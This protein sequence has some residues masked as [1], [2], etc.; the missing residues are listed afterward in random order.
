MNMNI[1]EK[2][3]QEHSL[4]TEQSILMGQWEFD[5]K[6]I[7][8]ALKAIAIVFPHFSLHDESH[9]VSILNN[10]VKMLGVDNIKKLSCTD[11]WLLLESAYSHDLGMVVTAERLDETL[12]GEDILK[13][14]MKI[15]AD[16][17]HPCYEYSKCFVI[18]DGKLY[19]KEQ[20]LK[21]DK[22]DAVRFLLADYFR[23]KHAEN[24]KK[25]LSSPMVEA[26]ISS[27]RT[28]IP[29]RLFGMLSDIC[30]A[31][32]QNFEAVM[33]LPQNEDGIGLDE[34]HPRF[35]ACML[36][37][38][39]LRDI[40]NNRFSESLMKTIK[41]MPADSL[42]H[43]EK[44][45]SISH[46]S[47][48]TKC[49]EIEAVCHSPKVAQVTQE[50]FD[51]ISDEF[52]TQTLK[53]NCIVPDGIA[54]YL[55]TLNYLR[56]KI[57]G[58]E[59]VNDNK[60]PKF[61]IDTAKAL[62]L[63]QG[64]N[65]YKDVFDALREIIQNAVDSTLIRI[66]LDSK[67]DGEVFDGINEDFLKYAKQYEIKV[68]LRTTEDGNFEVTIS[69]KGM[70]LKPEHLPF[71]INTGSSSKNIE[72][73]LII[74]EMPE[75]MRPSGVFG[76][77]F[78]SIFLLTDKVEITTK[79]YFEDKKMNIEMYSPNSPM[80]GDVYL[81][82]VDGTYDKGFTI[83]F[84][85]KKDVKL[86]HE[87][88]YFDSVPSEIERTFV[89]DRIRKDAIT[90][91]VPIW[92]YVDDMPVDKIERREFCYFDK[93]T[94][95]E[96]GF[97]ESITELS[98]PSSPSFYYRNAP[99]SGNG[100]ETRFISPYVNVHFGSAMDALTLDRSSF[101]LIGL[102]DIVD[103]TIVNFI[104]SDKFE[105]YIE[106]LGKE[107]QYVIIKLDGFLEYYNLKSKIASGKISS[108]IK[109]FTFN[110]V[111]GIDNKSIQKISSYKKIRIQTV[112]NQIISFI[113]NNPDEITI[114]ISSMHLALSNFIND[115]V[116]LIVKMAND[117]HNCCY[118][119]KAMTLQFFAGSEYVMSDR[120][121]ESDISLTMGDIKNHLM[122]T[123]GRFYV[124][125]IPGYNDIRIPSSH[126]D[127]FQTVS[128]SNPPYSGIS[129]ERI[130]SPFVTINNATYDCRNDNFYRYVHSVNGVDVDK[131]RESYDRFVAEAQ[132]F[133]L[134]IT[135]K[136]A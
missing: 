124:S 88:D 125:Y 110:N 114:E 76:I 104:N 23:S 102:K 66:Y 31:H 84:T 75:W 55:P 116:K 129:V 74:D 94:L 115:I 127:D 126:K 19:L 96:I 58:Y 108:N 70:G 16:E 98:S 136:P 59:T 4:N 54:C 73:K 39:D 37:L 33:A 63:L 131:I 83:K 65:F 81:K 18:K 89:E 62:E 3:L 133:G 109:G 12:K 86:R 56:T 57:E 82:N 29:Q 44:H 5:K 111:F 106:S 11:L 117:G 48:N 69:D 120:F 122:H 87:K 20:E 135:E 9:S 77:G 97:P 91:F 128:F 22:L 27:P 38:G 121:V 25:T 43:Y 14:Y 51:W 79:E 80:K 78:Q 113:E 134:K 50:W 72:R 90:S 47:I 24:S 8:N 68:W 71:L 10:I 13:H 42:A 95:V 46:L 132:R 35:I 41:A 93:S 21:T 53:W 52:K 49:I 85:I 103:E 119:S 6:N 7:P 1:I 101:K 32:T 30:R 15:A 26:G 40:D 64:R 60:K 130:L 45:K 36:R 118:C 17:N 92:L 105:T 99:V 67:K 123:V 34:C 2:I 100:V 112:S 107:S 61:T 28:I